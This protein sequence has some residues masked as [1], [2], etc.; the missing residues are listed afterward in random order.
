MSVTYHVLTDNF[1]KLNVYVD[2]LWSTCVFTQI[3]TNQSKTT[4]N[5]GYKTEKSS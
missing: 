4:L 1:D 2:T 5:R 3:I